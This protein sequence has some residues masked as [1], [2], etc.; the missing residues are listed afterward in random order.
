MVDI[1]RHRHMFIDISTI[2]RAL[3]SFC[4]KSA[5]GMCQ[6]STR[7]RLFF[8]HKRCTICLLQMV[9][10]CDMTRCNAWHCAR[11]CV[12]HD[13]MRVTWLIP[14]GDKTR[15]FAW[16]DSFLC[17]TCLSPECH[18]VTWLVEMRDTIRDNACDMTHSSVWHAPFLCV[19]WLIALCDMPQSSV[20]HD[21]F[22]FVP[23]L[24]HMCDMTHSYVWHDLL[25]YVTCLS[26]LCDISRWNAWRDVIPDNACDMTQFTVWHDSFL[27]DM[28]HWNAWHCARQCVWHDSMR[29]TWLVPVRDMRHSSEWYD[30][31][32][33]DS[34]LCV[35]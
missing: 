3:M 19:T 32:S 17:V 31:M 15:S 26:P 29:V 16:Q 4:K 8:L 24:I 33:H 21:S 23:W 5:G 13:S 18:G 20:W 22:I 11:Q 2:S 30:S 7:M 28:T 10:M 27:C 25:L 6:K 1:F 12:W 34:D 14:L 9:D 35:T